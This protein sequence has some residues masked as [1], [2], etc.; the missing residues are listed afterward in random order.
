M[1]FQ[2]CGT[3]ENMYGFLAVEAD[4]AYARWHCTAG[5]QMERLLSGAVRIFGPTSHELYDVGDLQVSHFERAAGAH[6][7]NDEEAERYW[8]DRHDVVSDILGVKR[9]DRDIWF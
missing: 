3:S 4:N 5:E 9:R 6:A 1:S 8:N 2:G 7:A